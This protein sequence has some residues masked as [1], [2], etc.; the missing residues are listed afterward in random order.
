M[1]GRPPRPREFLD[2]LPAYVAGSPAVGRDGRPGHKLSSNESPYPVPAT[3][4]A[5]MKAAVTRANRY[6]VA[7]RELVSRLATKHAVPT[8]MVAVAG[9]S[10]ELLRDLLCA[11]AG[12]GSEVVFGWRSY[13]AY[14]ILV[15]STGAHSVRV[16]LVHQG[17]DLERMEAAITD[18]TKVVL[19]ANPNNPTG[20]AVDADALARLSSRIPEQCVL[21]LDEAYS[22]YSEPRLGPQGIELARAAAN[23]VVMR[24]FSKAY[25]LA[26]MRIGWC[27]AHPDVVETLRRVALPFTLTAVAQAA[28]L[29]ALDTENLLGAQVR[30]TIAERERMRHAL[31][32]TGMSVPESQANFLW[33]PL[34]AHSQA[35]A[36]ACSAAGISVRCFPGDGVRVTIGTPSENQSFLDFAVSEWVTAG[37]EEERR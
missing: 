4:V 23:V 18:Q 24:T 29:A 2:Q 1:T 9:G 6:P 27:V 12:Q 10:L 17:L 26:G 14:P 25:A 8:E 21:V 32:T 3:M 20:T 19:V 36:T 22:E 28:A 37:P 16:P 35:F 11:Y 34:A 33:L 7:D 30:E 15:Q 13:E 5:A 31:L